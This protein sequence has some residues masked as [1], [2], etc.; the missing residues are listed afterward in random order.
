MGKRKCKHR[1]HG[2]CK[3]NGKH[4]EHVYDY[5]VIGAGTAGGVVAKELSD[6]CRT[7]VLTLE[8]GTNMVEELSGASNPGSGL[9]AT[10]NRHSFQVMSNLEPNINSQ[11]R[12]SSGRAIGGRYLH[13]KYRFIELIISPLGGI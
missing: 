8:A 1:K 6:D 7:S 12:L 4:C 3:K 2:K 11:L 13:I 5:I 10:D 9:L